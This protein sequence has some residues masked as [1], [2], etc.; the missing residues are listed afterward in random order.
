[1]TQENAGADAV[2][3]AAAGLAGGAV[4]GAVNAF[5]AASAVMDK[6]SSAQS[7]QKFHVEKDTVLQAGKVIHDQWMMLDKLY[8]EKVEKLRI[9]FVGDKVTGDVVEAWN[10]RL[11]FHSDSYANRIKAYVDSLKSLSDQLKA[12]AEQYGYTDEEIQTTFGSKQ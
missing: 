2:L 12:S 7:T 9:K 11:V 6:I 10:D 5:A 8:L 1:M 3:S 4:A